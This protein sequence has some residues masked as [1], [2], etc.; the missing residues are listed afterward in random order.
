M[1][2]SEG[3]YSKEIDIL[4]KI[5]RF[6]LQAITGRTQFHFGEFRKM[7]VAENIVNA[8]QRRAQSKNWAEW[9]RDNG[10]AAELLNEAERLAYGD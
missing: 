2:A 4:R 10:T 3:R 6:G 7:I 9:G 5:D 8:Y 1:Y